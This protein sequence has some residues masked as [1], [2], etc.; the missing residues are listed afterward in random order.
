[1]VICLHG[2]SPSYTVTALRLHRFPGHIQAK[3]RA[4]TCRQWLAGQRKPQKCRDG[5]LLPAV[6]PAP[7]CKAGAL[8]GGWPVSISANCE[9]NADYNAGAAVIFQC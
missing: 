4:R 6:R 1:M 2:K 8:L 5:S 3:L 9:A 7:S